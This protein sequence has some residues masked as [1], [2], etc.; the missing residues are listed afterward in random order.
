VS[1]ISLPF[2]IALLAMLAVCAVWFTVLKPKAPTAA[3]ATPTTSAPGVTGLANDVQAAKGAAKTSDAANAKVQNATGGTAAQADKPAAA[4]AKTPA[5]TGKTADPETATA[6]AAP[7]QKAPARTATPATKAAADAT[8]PLLTALGEHKAVV[9][10]FYNAKGSDDRAVRAAAG[11]ISHRHGRVIV[12]TVPLSRVGRYAPITTGVAVAQTPTVMVL[13][14]GNTARTIV[15]FTTEGEI[16]Q[17]VG[18]ALT[19]KTGK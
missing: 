18:D 2:R 17:L 5:A 4:Q 10:V 15:G 19:A 8:A 12:K 9:L 6:K 14:P 3:T 1:Q 7:A 16:D 11:R 13:A